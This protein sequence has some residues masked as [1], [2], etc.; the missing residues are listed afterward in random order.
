[1]KMISMKR[2]T[3][4]MR[5]FNNLKHKSHKRISN[6]MQMILKIHHLRNHLIRK[7]QIYLL[8][9]KRR[10]LRDRRCRISHLI[11]KLKLMIVRKQIQ[12]KREMKLM[13]VLEV[14]NNSSKINSSSN[15]NRRQVL[16]S[17]N[18]NKRRQVMKMMK[19]MKNKC[20]VLIIQR[21]MLTCKC[22]V[23]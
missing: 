8:H 17:S 9:L 22:R 16:H 2:S 20:Q 13:L 21:T 18:S 11:Q 10:L 3:M 12:M 7:A 23:M 1:M 15:K 6:R 5:M 4:M 19:K 14:L